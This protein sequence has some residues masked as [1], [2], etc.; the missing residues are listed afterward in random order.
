MTYILLLQV[1][2]DE[3]L[4]LYQSQIDKRR[5]QKNNELIDSGFDLYCPEES[6]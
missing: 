1:T 5:N 3:L 6:F 4:P 2:N